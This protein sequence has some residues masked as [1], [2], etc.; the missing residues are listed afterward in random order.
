MPPAI[1][2]KEPQ[3]LLVNDTTKL[4]ESYRENGFAVAERFFDAEYVARLNGAIEEVLDVPDVSS[5]AELE[6]GD[7][8]IPR[9]IWSP[10]KRHAAFERTVADPRLLDV[11]E[12]LVGPDILFHYSKLHMKGPRVGSVVE[13]HQD[14][15]YYP[16]TNTD[17]VTA[18]VY[19][20]AATMQ[21]A[22]LQALP[23]SHRLGLA[24]HDVDGYFRGKVTRRIRRIGSRPRTAPPIPIRSIS[25][26]TRATTS[27]A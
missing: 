2:R 22:C 13:W 5:V 24:D 8:A 16:H 19:L 10:T 6:P 20:D 7:A 23:G 12:Q 27:P 25:A 18:M 4:A 21:N 26:R 14:F 17:L 3:R 11:I 1:V 9:R 15:S